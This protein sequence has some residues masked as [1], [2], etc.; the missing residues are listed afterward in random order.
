MQEKREI[1]FLKKC[2]NLKYHVLF[3][4]TSSKYSSEEKYIKKSG[5]ILCPEHN[6]ARFH[7]FKN[8]V[9][10]SVPKQVMIAEYQ[11]RLKRVLP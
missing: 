3:C 7:R 1:K 5:E 2:N 9:R 10:I 6:H 4:Y 8:A 11:K